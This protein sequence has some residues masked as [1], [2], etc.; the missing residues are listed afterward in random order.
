MRFPSEAPDGPE[1]AHEKLINLVRRI[2]RGEPAATAEVRVRVRRI[3]AFR[4]YGMSREDRFDLEQVVLLQVW[5][6]VGR[7]DFAPEGFWGFV[8]VLA[9]RRAID[10]WRV[11]RPEVDFEP[12]A[13]VADPSTGPLR[14][15][16][17][18]EQS[19]LAQAALERLS[20]EC[21][22]LIRLHVGSR[23]SYGELAQRLGK[24]EGA[25]RVQ[26]HRCIQRASRILREMLEDKSGPEV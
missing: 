4:G 10:W 17:D 12:P 8:E 16:L 23:L 11:R 19:E 7:P 26:M 18:R 24:S 15:V 3:L 22:E 21:Q 13:T 9:S 6:A 5:Q 2:R 1:E 20:P 14:A 25:L